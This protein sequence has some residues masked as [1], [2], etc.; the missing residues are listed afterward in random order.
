MREVVNTC[1]NT[2]V[3]EA[4]ENSKAVLFSICYDSVTFFIW[5]CGGASLCMPHHRPYKS[6]SAAF[7][8]RFLSLAKLILRAYVSIAIAFFSF[9]WTEGSGDKK[10]PLTILRVLAQVGFLEQQTK[11]YSLKQLWS[12]V[13]GEGKHANLVSSNLIRV[14]LPAY[15]ERL[16]T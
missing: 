9:I 2:T 11:V 12:H 14:K 16:R 4:R 10:A 7:L 13:G 8:R 1:F 3:V 5:S 6:K 15:I